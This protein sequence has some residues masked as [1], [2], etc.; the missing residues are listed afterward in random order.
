MKPGDLVLSKYTMATLRVIKVT[1]RFV[2]CNKVEGKPWKN[3]SRFRPE[4][5]VPTEKH[6]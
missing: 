3:N 6:R 2:Y 4:D 5:L 1:E